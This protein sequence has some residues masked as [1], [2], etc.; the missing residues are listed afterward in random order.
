MDKKHDGHAWCKI[1]TTSIKNDFNLTFQKKPASNFQKVFKI[2]L[3][4]M[5]K[6]NIGKKLDKKIFHFIL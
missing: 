5:L 6:Y 4:I 3:H 1:K 2:F